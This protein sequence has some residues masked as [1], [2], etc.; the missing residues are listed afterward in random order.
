MSVTRSAAQPMPPER[1]A[2]VLVVWSA[3][4]S[5]LAVTIAVGGTGT[6]H[7]DDLISASLWAASAV[8]AAM[9]IRTRRH[10]WA[11]CMTATGLA[12][13]CGQVLAIIAS[14]PTNWTLAAAAD[15]V[16]RGTFAGLAACWTWVI[17]RR[18][19]E[20]CEV[21]RANRH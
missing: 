19:C 6:R 3:L 12:A 11:T 1:F 14:P 13:V 10:W 20:V 4:M 9:T 18:L 17:G 16:N 7:G 8:A 21:L 2:S 5:V 15:W